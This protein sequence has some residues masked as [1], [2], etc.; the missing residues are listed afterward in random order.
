M[1]KQPKGR[2]VIQHFSPQITITLILKLLQFHEMKAN[3]LC[4]ENDFMDAPSSEQ[5]NTSS[6]E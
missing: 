1:K 5:P 3:I 2:N 4:V 6:F